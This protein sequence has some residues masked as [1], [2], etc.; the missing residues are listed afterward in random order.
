MEFIDL[1]SPEIAPVAGPPPRLASPPLPIHASPPSSVLRPVTQGLAPAVDPPPRLASPP[2][3]VLRPR[4]QTT[5]RPHRRSTAPPRL[6]SPLLSVLHP[7]APR[8]A[9]GPPPP[10]LVHASPTPPVPRLY[11]GA[12]PSYQTLAE[13]AR[14]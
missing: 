3:W 7:A 1:A 10:S 8:L 11:P 12:C 13:D 14:N 6:A 2:P 5:P 9:A 4:R